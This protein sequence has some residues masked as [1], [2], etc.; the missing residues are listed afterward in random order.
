MAITA[1]IVDGK[2]NSDFTNSA[3]KKKPM[4]SKMGYDEFLNLLCAEMQ[5]QDPLEPTKNTD[6]VAQMATFSQLEATLA[7]KDSVGTSAVASESSLANSLVGKNVIVKDTSSATGFTTGTVDYVMYKDGSIFMSI[8]NKLY[9]L[10]DLDT[11]A[12]DEYYEAV[13]QART[14]NSMIKELPELKNVTISY[15]TAI[16]QIR[17]LYDGLNEYQKGFVSKDDL[18][19]LTRYE[20]KMAE[21]EDAEKKKTESEG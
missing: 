13:V 12:N 10:G 9:E 6:Y 11:I 17:A 5:Y 16:E 4:G 7:M 21:L 20:S 19:T 1:N 14:V 15:K 18:D 2:V 3:E 8:E